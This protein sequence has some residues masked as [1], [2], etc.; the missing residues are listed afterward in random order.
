MDSEYLQSWARE[1]PAGLEEISPSLCHEPGFVREG[2]EFAGF[3]SSSRCLIEG[4]RET[5]SSFSFLVQPRTVV[6]A[7]NLKLPLENFMS[8]R[9]RSLHPPAAWP[10]PRPYH[11]DVLTAFTTDCPFWAPG[12]PSSMDS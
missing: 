1:T 6:I 5:G 9:M 8:H 11:G 10:V 4:K 2:R 7:N 3:V 12:W